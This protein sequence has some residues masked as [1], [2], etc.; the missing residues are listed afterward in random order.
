VRHPDRRAGQMYWSIATVGCKL[1][2][3][4]ANMRRELNRTEPFP[5][6]GCKSS[7]MLLID[8]C[9]VALSA[10]DKSTAAQHELGEPRK[11]DPQTFVRPR[12]SARCCFRRPRSKRKAPKRKVTMAPTPSPIMTPAHH[13]KGLPG[14]PVPVHDVVVDAGRMC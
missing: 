5:F 1:C 12:A 2:C 11:D 6:T 14:G 4:W 7:A 8:L 10:R 9:L 13:G 3:P